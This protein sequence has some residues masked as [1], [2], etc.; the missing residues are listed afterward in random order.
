MQSIQV[1]NRL[2]FVFDDRVVTF[3]LGAGVTFEEVASTLDEL[4][5]KQYGNPIGIDFMLAT[6]LPVNS[7]QSRQRRITLPGSMMDQ[8]RQ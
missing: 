3:G 2:R 8:A 6:R 1:E 4:A 5:Y 7:V